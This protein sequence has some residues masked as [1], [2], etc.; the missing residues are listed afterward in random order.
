M[1]TAIAIFAVLLASLC[2]SGQPAEPLQFTCYKPAR[3][4]AMDRATCQ[5]G[6][7]DDILEAARRMR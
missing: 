7:C 6:A 2:I 1:R 3:E 4:C 5:D